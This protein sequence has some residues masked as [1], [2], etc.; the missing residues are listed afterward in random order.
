MLPSRYP[1]RLG[2]KRLETSSTRIK[3]NNAGTEKILVPYGSV[4]GKFHRDYIQHT[5]DIL[6]RLV[7]T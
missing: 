4:R 7:K 3:G 6:V 5:A 1:L 2:G